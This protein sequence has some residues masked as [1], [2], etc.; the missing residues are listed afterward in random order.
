M[1][2]PAAAP[3]TERLA[4]EAEAPIDVARHRPARPLALEF[5]G[6][7][8]ESDEETSQDDDDDGESEGQP[9]AHGLQDEAADGALP[10]MGSALHAAGACRRCCFFAKGRCQN[11]ARCSFCHL[12]HER[13]SRGR[14]C[15]GHGGA[16]RVATPSAGLSPWGAVPQVP[17]GYGWPARAVASPTPYKPS[18][19]PTTASLT[20][21]SSA[22]GPLGLFGP[23]GLEFPKAVVAPPTPTAL[24]PAPLRLPPATSP[25]LQPEEL[26]EMPPPPDSSPSGLPSGTWI[27][28]ALRLVP[29]PP[30]EPPRNA[31]SR[32]GQAILGTVPSLVPGLPIG[33]EH[34]PRLLGA[35]RTRP[36]LG[37]APTKP[38]AA[39]A[40]LHGTPPP[41]LLAE[42]PAVRCPP[43]LEP[44]GV[45]AASTLRR[46]AAVDVPPSQVLLSGYFCGAGRTG[47][48]EPAK[49]PQW[50]R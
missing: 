37:T 28:G 49:I 31:S 43:G 47:A 29:P 14:G 4:V 7:E 2:E 11:G 21:R 25:I 19:T 30:R 13:R 27:A 1:Q 36:L 33:A 26:P 45:G 23:P 46:A 24:E 44:A 40:P 3:E 5:A 41:G 17:P 20:C 35:S 32:G 15:R 22:A 42:K 10:S 50:L 18:S 16:G 8:G 6:Q 9:A 39:L 34:L 12:P 38:P 48:L